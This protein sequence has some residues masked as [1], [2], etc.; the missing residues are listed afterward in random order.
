M[1]LGRK[2][3]GRNFVKGS[4]IPGPG[5]PKTP[6][7]LKSLRQLT[8]GELKIM[9]NKLLQASPEELKSFRGNVLE[10]TLASIIHKAIL[11]GDPTR[12]EFFMQR[13]WGKVPDKVEVTAVDELKQLSDQELLERV[14]TSVEEFKLKLNKGKSDE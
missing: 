4:A 14:A 11:S 13:L 9:M 2:T 6:D 3:G 8:V 7:E 10:M 1:A 12:L 5:R